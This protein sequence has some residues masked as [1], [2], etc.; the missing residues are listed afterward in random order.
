[1]KLIRSLGDGGEHNLNRTLSFQTPHLV[2][3]LW[4]VLYAVMCFLITVMTPRICSRRLRGDNYTAP[5]MTVATTLLMASASGEPLSLSVKSRC[6]EPMSVCESVGM[7]AAAATRP[8]VC[9]AVR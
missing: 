9:S 5:S 8:S 2:S 3:F 4:R 6:T 7:S 1:M